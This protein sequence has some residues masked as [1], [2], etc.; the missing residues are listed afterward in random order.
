MP[1]LPTEAVNDN[2]KLENALSAAFDLLR[3][4]VDASIPRDASFADREAQT[5]RLG[6]ELMRR[7]LQTDLEL[8]VQSHGEGPLRIGERLYAQHLE[9]I[10]SYASLV[11]ALPIQRATYREVGI[12]N[13]PTLVSL[14]LAAGLMERVTPALA[15]RILLGHGD[16]N[17]R[18]L[19]RELAASFRDVPSRSTLAKSGHR[20]GAALAEDAVEIER[21]VREDE[22][23]PAGTHAIAIGLDRTSTPMRELLADA[24]RP[25]KTPK[26]IR[27]RPFPYEVNYRMAYVGTVVFVDSNHR[28]LRT[29][30]YGA[31]AEDGPDELVQRMMSDIR[32]AREQ[33][34]N[35]QLLVIQ[36]AAKEMW[37]LTTA[38][39]EAEPSLRT[40]YELIDHYHALEHFAEIAAAM[41]VDTKA[42]LDEWK[43]M[44]RQDD[45]AIDA[46][47]QEVAREAA[48]P[49]LPCYRIV[50][51]EG[52]V[53][54]DNNHER[55]HY[56]N[57]RDAGLPIGSGPTE[58]A[59]K[60]LITIRCKRSG[61][62]WLTTGLR[63][64]IAART[65]LLNDRLPQA[66]ALLRQRHYTAEIKRAA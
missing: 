22:V 3:N 36:D 64:V 62:S 59:W 48:E 58:G 21:I 25:D 60:S 19:T 1:I 31:T 7:S 40:W 11:G 5:L 15:H 42:K 20:L 51:E 12:R 2:N 61:Q 45:D 57:L 24:E 47:R 37:H 14:E 46:I 16:T 56:A 52:L 10:V 63:T 43:C 39:L 33:R 4:A 41:E 17:S 23:L 30:R 55:L 27:E 32:R 65:Q 53:Y 35:L 34:R 38:A 8:L 9:G 44:L 54:L 66:V 50:L 18:R 28:V 13:G 29:V 6:N 49:Y 26:H